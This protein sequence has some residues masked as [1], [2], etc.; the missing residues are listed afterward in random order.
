MII[1]TKICFLS[2]SQAKLEHLGINTSSKQE[3]DE[4]DFS[5]DLDAVTG[6][7]QPTD[8]D[9]DRFVIFLPGTNGLLIHHD[10]KKLL[11]EWTVLKYKSKKIES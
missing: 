9:P 10:Y 11:H 3:Y 7:N 8:Q 4:G 6:I 5:F 2:D 1:K